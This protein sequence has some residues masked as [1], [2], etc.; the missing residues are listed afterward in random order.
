MC[1]IEHIRGALVVM[2]AADLQDPPE[3]HTSVARKV[4]EW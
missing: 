3:N 1:G 4:A 2:M